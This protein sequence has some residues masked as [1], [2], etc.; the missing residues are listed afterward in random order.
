MDERSLIARIGEII[1]AEHVRDDCALIESGEEYLVVSTDMLHETTDFPSGMTDRQIGWMAV[2]VT[3]SDL[4]AM[5]A[6]P[7]AV[8]LAT[9]LDDWRRLE[10]ITEGA[11]AC[12][13]RYGAD[14]AGGDVDAHHELT[15]VSTGI[16]R[17]ARDLVVRRTG[18]Q[19]GDLICITGV[20]GRAQAGLAG[21]GA[22]RTA[23]LEPRPMV[24]EGR[25]L[26]AAG[27]S[28][29]MDVSDGLALSLHDLALVNACGFAL[30]AACIPRP[31]G[32]PDGEALG[33]A[34]F[35]GGDF[36]LLFTCPPGR[37]PVAGVTATVIGKVI[38]ERAVLLDGAV[39]DRRGYQHGWQ[40]CR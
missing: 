18:S 8:L 36:G 33:M 23:L 13:R 10:G 2:A 7:V 32:V 6:D 35:G 30:R 5:G 1:G 12:C 9:G 3:L 29:M 16:G 26:A 40:D 37:F 14:L 25:L 4:A 34:L 15:I 27:V 28:A 24:A 22:H 20:P 39:L 38:P 19:P 11:L 31:E 17:V 21:Y